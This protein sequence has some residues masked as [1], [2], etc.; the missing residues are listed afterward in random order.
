MASIRDVATRAGVSTATASRALRGL[1]SVATT[2]RSKVEQAAR[3]LDYVLPFN[4]SSLAS[5]RTNTVGVIAPYLTCWFVSAVI[6]GVE[7]ALRAAGMDLLLYSVSADSRERFYQEM[8]LRRRVDGVVVLS[9]TLAEHEAAALR[10]LRIPVGIVSTQVEGFNSVSI[11]DMAAAETAVGHLI[12]LGHRRIGLISETEQGPTGFPV[13]TRRRAGYLSAL[14]QVGIEPD[15]RLQVD[16]GYKVT[17]AEYAMA[18]LLSRPDRPTAVFA[19]TDI[20]A[21]GA[22][23]AIRRHGLSVPE[24][25]SLIG[26]DDHD[27]AVTLDLSTIR[28]PVSEQG[29]L[30]ARS[31]LAQLREGAEPNQVLLPT[32]LVMRASTAPLTTPDTANSRP[33]RALTRLPG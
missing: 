3:D 29:A 26:V 16:G 22:L 7:T 8:P 13:P 11:D 25:I 21:F 32:R 10:R 30:V 1:T 24:D 9:M 31:V 23:R 5:G 6:A 12:N 20:M 15:P 2:T 18:E 27:L 33:A 19:G 4:A 28:Q 14:R 17:T